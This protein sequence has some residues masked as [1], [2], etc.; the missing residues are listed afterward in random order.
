M[1]YREK[2]SAQALSILFTQMQYQ[3]QPCRAVYGT[4]QLINGLFPG[5]VMLC[6][7]SRPLFHGSN[8]CPQLIYTVFPLHAAS[9]FL[10]QLPPQQG[11]K[12]LGAEAPTH[13]AWLASCGFG[14]LA[15]PSAAQKN[16]PLPSP[17]SKAHVLEPST[18]SQNRAESLEAGSFHP[19]GA[20]VPRGAAAQGAFWGSP[21]RGH[22]CCTDSS[23]C[24]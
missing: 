6:A 20:R 21:C 8:S 17:Q 14:W 18:A 19:A 5:S 22:Q 4:I 16:C 7:C 10:T 24:R 9:H 3:N 12:N 23:L 13:H 1:S 2:Q 15:S 11:I